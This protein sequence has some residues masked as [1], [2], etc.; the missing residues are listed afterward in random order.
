MS[1][2]ARPDM[3]CRDQK[4]TPTMATNDQ[5]RDRERLIEVLQRELAAAHTREQTAQEQEVLRLRAFE[6][7]QKQ[8]EQVEQQSSP[9]RQR[10]TRHPATILAFVDRAF[11]IRAAFR[12]GF[13]LLRVVVSALLLCYGASAY[14]HG[15]RTDSLGHL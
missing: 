11:M 5:E 9:A 6:Q 2:I 1:T 15:V 3:A 4:R 12:H 7:A 13:P 14:E 8:V 10:D